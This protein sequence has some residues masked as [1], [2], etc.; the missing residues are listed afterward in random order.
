MISCCLLCISNDLEEQSHAL[1]REIFKSTQQMLLN[2]VNI[3][4][5][6]NT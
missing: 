2:N 4:A 3:I 1:L 6:A 5:H